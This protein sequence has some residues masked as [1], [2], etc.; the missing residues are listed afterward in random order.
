MLKWIRAEGVA[1]EELSAVLSREQLI[2]IVHYTTY[3]ALRDVSPL[4]MSRSGL[5][6]AEEPLADLAVKLAELVEL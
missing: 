2:P 6:T 4:L 1:E 3:E 5:D